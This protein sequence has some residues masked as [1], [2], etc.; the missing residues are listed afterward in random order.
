MTIIDVLYLFVNRQFASMVNYI[1]VMKMKKTLGEKIK[2]LREDYDLTQ[3]ALGKELNMTQRKIS[4]LENDKYE[5]SI[6]DIR[7]LCL[8]FNVSSDY[9]LDLPKGLKIPIQ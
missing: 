1:W 9:L 3:V 7:I 8:F 4:Y 6:E 2:S 5:P